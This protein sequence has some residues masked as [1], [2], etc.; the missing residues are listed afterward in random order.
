MGRR[1]FLDI[2]GMSETRTNLK[3]IEGS[4]VKNNA[5]TGINFS[6][7]RKLQL[8]RKLASL[9]FVAPCIIVFCVT[10]KVVTHNP[11]RVV[12]P[13]SPF[14]ISVINKKAHGRKC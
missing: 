3:R 13:I 5:Y 6:F 1:S 8:Y 9:S 12:T 4:C 14:D 2:P 11:P 10:V 7:T